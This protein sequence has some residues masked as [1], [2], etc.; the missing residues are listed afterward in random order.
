MNRLFDFVEK[1]DAPFA[2]EKSTG[3]VFR[4]DS[5]S[6]DTWK[7]VE[8]D[9]SRAKIRLNS[10]PISESDAM[11]FADEMEEASPHCDRLLRSNSEATACSQTQSYLLRFRN[12]TPSSAALFAG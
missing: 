5:R 4:M 8:D 9:E 7:V 12:P 10:N 1:E 3:R 2:V 11:L 6:P